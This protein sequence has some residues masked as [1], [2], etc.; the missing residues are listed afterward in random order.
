MKKGLDK[1]SQFSFPCLSSE[2]QLLLTSKVRTKIQSDARLNKNS[3]IYGCI[4]YVYDLT[5]Q[6]YTNFSIFLSNLFGHTG[7]EIA[8]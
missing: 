4:F 1:T 3:K 8:F 6:E 2:R 5:E 7:S